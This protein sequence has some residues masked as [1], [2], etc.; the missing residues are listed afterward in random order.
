MATFLA[1][2]DEVG[3]H[4]GRAFFLRHIPSMPE[5]GLEFRLHIREGSR[6]IA[7]VTISHAPGWRAALQ[8]S[9]SIERARRPYSGS[10][11]YMD[12]TFGRRGGARLSDSFTSAW[13]VKCTI[14]RR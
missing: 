7:G 1:H 2:P 5:W 8:P 9:G 12:S 13:R 14:D 11:F 4:I 6:T 3:Q 10:C